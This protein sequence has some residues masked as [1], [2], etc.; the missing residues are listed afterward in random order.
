MTYGSYII[1]LSTIRA[2]ICCRAGLDALQSNQ[3]GDCGFVNPSA[4]EAA[5]ALAIARDEQ[6]SQSPLG[7][8]NEPL[9]ATMPDTQQSSRPRRLVARGNR[10]R[11]L[12]IGPDECADLGAI[13]STRPNGRTGA[14]ESL[15]AKG[16]ARI[17]RAVPGRCGW[18][19]A[20][21]TLLAVSLPITLTGCGRKTQADS[22]NQPTPATIEHTTLRTGP[23]TPLDCC[24]DE[25]GDGI[26][27]S[28]QLRS[29]DDKENFRKW[30]TS[31]AE[32]QFY[33][34]GSEWNPRQRDCAGLVRFAMR[35]ALRRHDQEWF[36]RIGPG[37]EGVAPDVRAFSLETGPLGDKLF[38]TDY[39]AFKKTDLTD[40]KFS[41]FADAHTLKNYNCTFVSRDRSQARAGDLLFYYQPWV[42]NYPYHVMIFLGRARE[43]DDGG[44]DW[45]VYHTGSSASDQ[46]TVKKVRLAV[47]DHHPDR[48]WRPILDNPHFVGF[49]RLKILK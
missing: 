29:F 4:I 7:N 16:G 30:F 22:F 18:N 40:G 9:N 49:Y 5:A 43:A 23:R 21:V 15:G 35:E 1:R 48:R 8:R 2:D 14:L 46:G 41:E 24:S 3:L 11:P 20:A 31:I 47:L 17:L 10:K 6:R 25:D 37:Y 36:Q 27:D 45:V 39:G 38:R 33:N 34:P 13:G 26:P 32:M 44:S 12:D 28:A 19:L 42:Q